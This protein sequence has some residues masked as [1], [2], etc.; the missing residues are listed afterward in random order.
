[1]SPPASIL[2]LISG[3]CPLRVRVCWVQL[4][5]GAQSPV[6]SLKAVSRM[7]SICCSL[8]TAVSDGGNVPKYGTGEL[9]LWPLTQEVDTS[10][11]M[12]PA[13][14]QKWALGFQLGLRAGGGRIIKLK[15]LVLP[16]DAARLALPRRRARGSIA[17]ALTRRGWRAFSRRLL[18]ARLA[19]INVVCF[20]NPPTPKTWFLS[21][22]P[23]TDGKLQCVKW[24]IKR[25]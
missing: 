9:S 7:A 16:G 21:S 15:W 2:A 1:M 8:I 24:V 4:E 19:S 14:G 23:L 6:R 13:C 11:L 25:C 18:I 3:S 5:T 17:P 12:M 20:S 10:R 22:L